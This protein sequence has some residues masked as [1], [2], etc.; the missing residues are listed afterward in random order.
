MKGRLSEHDE[1]LNMFPTGQWDW[2]KEIQDNE[3]TVDDIEDFKKAIS[4]RQVKVL[5][6]KW[7]EDGVSFEDIKLL[8]IPSSELVGTLLMKRYIL[9]GTRPLPVS[10]SFDCEDLAGMFTDNND[11]NMDY[12]K[13]F[14]CGEPTFWDSED[15]YNYEWDD[16]MTDQIDEKNWKTISQI[17]G[18]VTQS[19]AED[20]LNRSSSSEEI[21]ELIEKYDDEIEEIRN[22]ITWTHNDEN[23]WAV[24]DAMKSDILDK[25][26]GHFDDGQLF[27]SEEDNSYSWYFEGRFKKTG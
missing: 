14:L 13:E 25:L 19:V 15:W 7:D 20:I 4:E 12:I 23:E 18:G 10:F 8:G 17:F 27:R 21:D 1:Q 11:Y 22:F 24:K 5:F 16:Y 9:S 6:N 26:E 3:F 2:P